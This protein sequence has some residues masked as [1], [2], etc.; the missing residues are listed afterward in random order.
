MS[1]SSRASSVSRSFI[2]NEAMIPARAKGIVGGS[3]GEW[4][5]VLG[6]GMFRGGEMSTLRFHLAR[7]GEEEGSGRVGVDPFLLQLELSNVL[8]E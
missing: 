3:G 1:G 7:E 2:G 8:L 4:V 5:H 6:R